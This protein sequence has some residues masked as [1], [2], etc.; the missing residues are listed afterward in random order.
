[1]SQRSPLARL[2]VLALATAAAAPVL[3][4]TGPPRPSPKATVSQTAGLTEMTVSYSSPA[5]RGRQVWGAL[6]PY[7]AVW[8]TGANEATTFKTTTD[9]QVEGKALP[10]G[11]YAL[12]TIPKKDRWTVVFNKQA[13]Q[14]GAFNHD[15][16]ADVLSVDVTPVEAPFQERMGFSFRDFTD[17]SATLV[18]GWEKVAVPV[19]ITFD[20]PKLALERAEKELAAADAKPGQLI[21]WSRWLTQNDLAADKALAWVQRATATEQGAKSYWGKA[22]EARLLAKAGKAAE[23]KAAA[24]AAVPL[25]A[26]APD[27]EVAKADAAKLQQEAAGWK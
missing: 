24:A 15:K 2:A 21:S 10:A 18:L 14:W 17:T 1:M 25:A 11:T 26:S 23:A 22:V 27:A 4:Q 3:A 6:V 5:V 8:R 7:D 12:F 16:S 13:E 19:K 9:V 20:T